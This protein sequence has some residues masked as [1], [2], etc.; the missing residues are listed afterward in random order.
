MNVININI[1]EE[2]ILKDKHNVIIEDNIVR[3]LILF[4]ST[5]SATIVYMTTKKSEEK[6]LSCN[7]L[8]LPNRFLLTDDVAKTRFVNLC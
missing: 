5:S 7:F 2:L 1:I 4:N 8:M 3:G 6:T